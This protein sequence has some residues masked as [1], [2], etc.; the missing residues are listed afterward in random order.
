MA[1][2]V[3]VSLESLP[4]VRALIR[5]FIQV[6]AIVQ[7]E[8]GAGLKPLPAFIT[9]VGPLPSVDSLVSVQA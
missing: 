4:A 3:G 1:V 2:E 5:L 8:M 9:L 6:N 7:E